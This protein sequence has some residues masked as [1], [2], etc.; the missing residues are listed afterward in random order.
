M[1]GL[2]DVQPFSAV[3]AWPDASRRPDKNNPAR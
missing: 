3:R 2:A 1:S